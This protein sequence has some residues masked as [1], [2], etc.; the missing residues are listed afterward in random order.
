MRKPAVNRTYRLF[1]SN[2]ASVASASRR[3]SSVLASDGLAIM[4]DV[5][6]ALETQKSATALGSAIYEGPAVDW[7]PHPYTV[8][9]YRFDGS[10]AGPLYTFK[11]VP[12]E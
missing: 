8:R 6:V 1:C 12:G 10:S 5:V 4:A 11:F 3:D 9:R 2:F 7:L